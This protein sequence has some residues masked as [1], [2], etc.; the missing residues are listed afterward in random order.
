MG[1]VFMTRFLKLPGRG[2]TTVHRRTVQGPAGRG[3]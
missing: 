1:D 2:V 3:R